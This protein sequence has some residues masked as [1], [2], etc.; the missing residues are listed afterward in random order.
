[1][2]IT[3]SLQLL[4]RDCDYPKFTV[5]IVV[6]QNAYMFLLFFRFYLKTYVYKKPEQPQAAVDAESKPSDGGPKQS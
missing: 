2:I 3:H 6:S 5:P 4:F 1:M